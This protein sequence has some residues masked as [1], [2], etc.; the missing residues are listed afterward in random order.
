MRSACVLGLVIAS[1]AAL[2]H[3]LPAAP[4]QAWRDGVTITRPEGAAKGF[5]LLLHGGPSFRLRA[6]TLAAELGDLDYVVVSASLDT[7]AAWNADRHASCTAPAADLAAFAAAAL[8]TTGALPAAKPV[9]VGV[10]EAAALAYAAA[11]QAGTAAFHTV[12]SVDFCPELP[13][14]IVPCTGSRRL[15]P[16]G[17]L[18]PGW[19]LFQ[20]PDYG[21]CPLA[22]IQSFVGGIA[23]AKLAVVAPGGEP[24]REFRAIMQWLDPANA[25]QSAASGDVQGVPVIEVPASGDPRLALLMTGDGGWAEL[26]RAISRRLADRGIATVGWDALSYFWR[27]RTADELG[28]DFER[29]L[30]HYLEAWGREHILLVGYSYGADVLPFAISRLPADL[31]ARIALVALLGPGPTASFE[32]HLT[33]WLG[34]DEGETHAVAPELAKLA[35]LRVLCVYGEDEEAEDTLCPKLAAPVHVVKMPGDHHF[36]ADYDGLVAAIRRELE[37]QP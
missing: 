27:A 8:P 16:Q 23:N 2:L 26:D 4:F 25:R 32:F 20:R 28:R 7:Y 3:A 17:D 31:R 35:D 30:R 9:L 1:V 12:L 6:R 29:T 36:D 15:E 14:E 34:E 33:Q 10:G 13:R 21:A 18:H 37:A 19:F 5:V 24:D 22:S 11:A